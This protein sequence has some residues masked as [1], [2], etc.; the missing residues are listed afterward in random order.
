[1]KTEI[2]GAG[3]VCGEQ[4][5]VYDIIPES[6][7]TMKTLDGAAM[8]D[9]VFE[10]LEPGCQ[11]VPGA[12]KR[13]GFQVVVAGENFGCGTKSVEHPMAAMKGAGIELIIARSVS[14]YSYRNAINLSLPIL[15]CPNAPELFRR[16]DW[17]E[18]NCATGEIRN[19]TTGPTVYAQGLGNFAMRI[20]GA[21]GLM[22]LVEKELKQNGQ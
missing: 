10:T 19:L 20:I 17:I 9:W 6:R 5:T 3:C 21:G 16:G 1:M 14:R 15:I 2:T 8:G 13:L 4:V 22:T 18:A 11:N 7:W 12:F